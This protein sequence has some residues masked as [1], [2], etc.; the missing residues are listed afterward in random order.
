M[1]VLIVEDSEPMRRLLTS[2]VGEWADTMECE[3]GADA[4][5]LYAKHKPDWVLMDIRMKNVGGIEATRRVI[6]AHPEAQI[7]IVSNYEGK[8]LR[9]SAREAGARAYVLKDDLSSLW[10]ILTRPPDLV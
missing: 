10:R 7:V 2:I 6:A 3:D 9:K 8:Q 5:A 4:V 1:K